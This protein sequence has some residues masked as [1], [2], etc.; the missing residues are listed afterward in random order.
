MILSVSRRT[1]IPACYGGWFYNRIRA[2]FV[3]VRNPY[4]PRQVSHI[5]LKPEAVDCI[6]FWTKNPGLPAR[7]GGQAFMDGLPLLDG[8]GYKYYFQFTVTSYNRTIEPGVPRKKDVIASFRELS[9]K[10][11]AARVVWRYDPVF[12][13]EEYSAA[14]HRKYFAWIAEA[15]SGFTD[16][17]VISFVDEYP[18]IQGRMK[19][20]G[21][22]VPSEEEMLETAG[23]MA[24]AGRRNGIRVTA[25][26]EKTD[27]SAAGVTPSRCIDPDRIRLVAGAGGNSGAG[28]DDAGNTETGSESGAGPARRPEPKKASGQRPGYG[29]AESVDIGAYGTCTNGCVYCYAS[30]RQRSV[31]RCDPESP[32]LCSHLT[33][34]DTVHVKG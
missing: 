12:F 22:R 4:N 2:G 29:C 6:V 25:C 19:R 26:C 17:C 31:P 13:S 7:G 28:S 27:F 23:F 9:R 10:L 1:D 32:L 8:M 30:G 15:L 33:A 24:E 16:T 14:C 34:E 11:G 21:I 3:Q 5:N 20:C 18:A